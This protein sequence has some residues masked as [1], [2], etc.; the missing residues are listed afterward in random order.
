MLLKLV[1]LLYG[2]YAACVWIVVVFLVVCPLII[3]LPTLALRRAAGRSGMKLVM[4]AMGQPLRVRGLEHLPGVPCVVVANHASY[5]DGLVLTAALPARFNFVVQDGA[6]SWPYVGLVIRR[7]GVIFINRRSAREGARQ[8][9]ELIRRLQQGASLAVFPE[10]TFRKQPGLMNFRNGA[11]LVAA[12]ARAPVVPCAIRGTR[13]LLGEGQ[14]LPRYSRV[15]IQILPPIPPAEGND[16]AAVDALRDRA[17]RA[18]L[19]ACGEPDGR[20]AAR[21][22]A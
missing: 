15:S 4:L 10:G 18:V 22:G 16:R 11:F 21:D 2:A 6:A 1:R 5:M 8:T 12:H 17:R 19:E 9:R 3:C 13:Q 7:M 20:A 14:K